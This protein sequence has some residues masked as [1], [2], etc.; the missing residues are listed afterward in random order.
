MA[1]TAKELIIKIVGDT[2]SINKSLET[3]TKK[4]DDF[5]AKTK[6]INEVYGTVSKQAMIAT[7]AIAAMGVAAA[8]LAVDFNAGFANV[9][10]LIPGATESIKELQENVLALSPAVGK[11]TADL[12]DGLYEI[13][14]AFG[15][16]ADS[17]KNLELAAKGATAGGATTKNAI[18]L[19]SAVTKA[20]GDTTNAAQKKVSDFAFTT[21]KLG[22]T[23]F[24]EL[25]ASIQRVT[26]QSKNL[27][28]SQEELFA[29]FS[30]GTG[31][32]GGA[33]E[34][35]TKFSALLTEM[36]KPGDRLANTFKNLGVS[37][38]DELIE[39]FGSLQGALQALKKEADK[40]GEPISNLFGSAEA[41]KLAL[42]AAGEGAKKFSS[43]L[44]AMKNSIG[45]TEQAFKDATTEGPNAFGFQLQQSGLNA[46]A[47]AIKIGQE[48]IPSLQNLL[49]PLFK[50]TEYL[51]S[52]DKGTM[53]NIIAIGKI[54][55]TF[56]SV[57]AAVY[58][59]YK[60][61]IALKTG[62]DL[63][64]GAMVSNPFGVFVV[65]ATTAIVAIKELCEWF[66]R[67]SKKQKELEN[68]K[69]RLSLSFPKE[70]ESVIELSKAYIELA[71]KEKVSAEEKQKLKTQTEQLIK[72]APD[73]AG[74]LSTEE[75]GYKNNL[76]VLKE[77]N[78]EKIK[79]AKLNLANAK[80][81]HGNIVRT[82]ADAEKHLALL[83]Q[84]NELEL[85][86]SGFTS[87]GINDE[88]IKKETKALE[89]LIDKEKIYQEEIAKNELLLAKL[90]DT[91]TAL[92]EE[93][94]SDNSNK[95]S[96]K[97]GET[98]KTQ[99]E[100]LGELDKLFQ[101]EK[102]LIQDHVKDTVKQE[103]EITKAEEKYYNERMKLLDTFHTENLSKNMSLANSK[104][105]IVGQNSETIE[106]ETEKTCDNLLNIQKKRHTQELELL[107]HTAEKTKQNVEA[108]VNLKLSLQEIAGKNDKEKK[109][110]AFLE[111]ANRYA[112]KRNDLEQDYLNL[113]VS[114]NTNDK[115]KAEIIKTQISQL[116]EFEKAAEK[117]AK[118]LGKTFEEIAIN[119]AAKISELGGYVNNLMDSLSD[120]AK[121]IITN[122]ETTRK[123]ETAKELA[124]IER[125]KNE[126]LL[127]LDNELSQM[128]EEKQIEDAEREEARR[129][130]EHEKKLAEYDRNIQE[131]QGFFEI[132]TNKEKLR[133]QEKQLEAAR[134]KQAEELQRKKEE[135]DKRKRDKEARTQEVALL[136]AKALA[137]HEFALAR[138]QTENASGDAAA[139]AAQ[140]AAK[141]Q[142]AQGV[143]SMSIKAAEQ[144][145]LSV[146]AIARGLAGDPM[147][148]VESAARI[149]AATM[150]AVQAGV[151]GSQPLPPDYIMQPLPPAPRLIKF[152]H[153]GIVMPSNK[154]TGITLPNGTSGLVAEAGF[155]EMILPINA[156][157]LEKMFRAAG[158][159]QNNNSEQS[160]VIS[161]SPS[162]HIEISQNQEELLEDKILSVLNA[163]EREV[164][165]IVESGKK[166]F[167]VGE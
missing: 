103:K 94:K 115:E 79:E 125:E 143:I 166:N 142:K 126:T 3:T 50:A 118:A 19:L 117:N 23:N 124:N 30:S 49:T 156:P 153:G 34:V 165:N 104:L 87:F 32:I 77:F 28:I 106:K 24:P 148:Y 105:K 163:N 33:A 42:Y 58:G 54:I 26:S 83:K 150:A 75:T 119:I 40:T 37:S 91:K 78:E 2:E 80:N 41:G 65:G 4:I 138:I 135:N 8:K 167:F 149:A 139:K 84:T 44:E 154:G 20:Y 6:S 59:S 127:E 88:Q 137:E 18:A 116:K 7:T 101:I 152:A 12:T 89:D 109:R 102:Q 113:S 38:G 47:F 100:R 86:A 29:V 39:K 162:Y 52:M 108:E 60:A 157:N 51:A 13:V 66:E 25:A 158:V 136:N 90:K 111:Q 46:K 57:T 81:A 27:K 132:E 72:L 82:I 73:L 21:V 161:Y 99:K 68:K 129:S 11:S 1:I 122:Q 98:E 55:I 76:K 35:S 159:V 160:Q 97:K 110:N 62:F 134:K 96:E 10:T 31:V 145:A 141:W 112:Q 69:L 36:Q 133:N 45:A 22:Q 144:T 56:T 61:V 67:A 53:Q 146:I 151:I 64:K 95:T 14:S 15:D 16:S 123:Q 63:L 74:R 71:A 131:L 164:M 43:D 121:N 155:P 128:R 48:L 85:D 107:S 9:Q 93:T 147:G 140:Q 130:E 92:N 5:K 17:A 70:A 114:S 120:V